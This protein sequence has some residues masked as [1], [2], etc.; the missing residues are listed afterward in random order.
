MRVKS[1]S[2]AVTRA[3]RSEVGM[4]KR[5]GAPHLHA[6]KL[7]IYRALL[8]VLLGLYL[9]V[10]VGLRMRIFGTPAPNRRKCP[11]REER[12]GRNHM[13]SDKLFKG[14]QTVFLFV[15]LSLSFKDIAFTERADSTVCSYLIFFT[16]NRVLLLDSPVLLHTIRTPTQP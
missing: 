4:E 16:C 7:N 9:R 5:V 10:C 3:E 12:R 11:G 14:K 2:L 15:Y 6:I 1:L 8:N 13:N